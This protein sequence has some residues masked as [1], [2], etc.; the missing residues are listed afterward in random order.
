[1]SSV[2]VC[3]CCSFCHFF[4]IKKYFFFLLFSFFCAF[5][6]IHPSGRVHITFSVFFTSCCHHIHPL[7]LKLC[8]CELFSLASLCSF[9]QNTSQLLE[10]WCNL[11]CPRKQ[12]THARAHTHTCTYTPIPPR[13]DGCTLAKS[14]P[15]FPV[16]YK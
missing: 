12:N 1:M 14:G 13:V 11:P 3:H 15:M 5:L 8:V 4:Y 16:V 10:H 7:S 6:Y 2:R 9:L